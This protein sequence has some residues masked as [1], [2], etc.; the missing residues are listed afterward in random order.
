M[1]AELS[2]NENDYKTFYHNT[3]QGRMRHDK[4]HNLLV[5]T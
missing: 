2:N 3:K 1:V 4:V 5:I